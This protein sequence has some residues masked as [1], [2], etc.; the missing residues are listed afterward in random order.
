[1]HD[2]GGDCRPG[3][4][5]VSNSI[6]PY[7][8]NLHRLIVAGIPELQLHTLVTHGVGDF[9][10]S[11]DVPAEINSTNL[12]APGEHPIDHPLGRP[13]AEWQKSRRLISYLKEHR[14]AAV[15]INGYKYIPYLRR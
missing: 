1:M 2:R 13:W 4:V 5:I 14:A 10:W 8:V 9:N 15:V 7:R 11:V 12:S 3:L 6:T